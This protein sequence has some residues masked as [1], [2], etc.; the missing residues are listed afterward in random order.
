MDGK[1]LAQGIIAKVDELEKLCKGVDEVVASKAPEGRWTP[2]EI[3][4]HLVGEE[5]G[6]GITAGVRMFVDRDVP[7]IDII[8]EET[9]FSPG[10]AKLTFSQLMDR[11]DRD[12]RGLASYVAGLSPEQLGRKAHVPLFKDLPM[13]EYPTLEDFIGGVADYHLGFHMDH[14]K[15]ILQA[16]GALPKT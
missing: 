8:P 9:H 7:M 4:S 13:G 1:Q 15:E 10:R 14:M 16:L 11:F 5:E 12:Y 3:I 2:K 6:A